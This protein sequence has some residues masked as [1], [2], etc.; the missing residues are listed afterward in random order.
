MG[1]FLPSINKRQRTTVVV[2]QGY[3]R[4]FNTPTS[5]KTFL[6]NIVFSSVEEN[7]SWSH[8]APYNG[9][10]DNGGQFTLSRVSDADS[11]HWEYVKGGP[12]YFLY[13]GGVY[14][15]H[16]DQVSWWTAGLS[17]SVPSAASL[18]AAG[19]TAI[20]RC[21]PTSPHFSLAQSLGELREGAPSIPGVRSW[22]NRTRP[23]L[24]SVGDEYL[25]YQFG[26]L[27]LVSDVRKFYESTTKSDR[28]LDEYRRNANRKIRR[29]YDFPTTISTRT[30]SGSIQIHPANFGLFAPGT[31][32]ETVTTKRWFR[33]AFRYYLPPTD[34]YQGRVRRKLQE[35][36]HLFGVLPTPEVLW[37]LTPWSWAIDWFT[38]VGDVMSNISS[39][40]TDGLVLQYGYIMEHKRV[41]GEMTVTVPPS[42]VAQYG[43]T[44][45]ILKRTYVREYKCRYPANPYGFGIDDTSLTTRQLSILG[46]LGLSKGT[47]LN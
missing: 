34:S 17:G 14:P 32:S 44:G 31:I 25:N 39:F 11:L 13:T 40:A 23:L 45:P 10:Y 47:R 21:K 28:I 12:S 8:K 5:T 3:T 2:P 46:A 43:L 1:R 36:N 9:A 6:P 19:A 35:A 41:H 16:P 33:G 22:E 27:P 26:W 38:N 29:G 15:Q 30:G 7:M 37:E 24:G 20:A 4:I 42:Q 18:S